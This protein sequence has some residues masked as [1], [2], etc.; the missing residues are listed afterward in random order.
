MGF[1]PFFFVLFL[2]FPLF[3]FSSFFFFFFFALVF[4][5]DARAFLV[6]LY[7]NLS[8]LRRCGL[9]IN[10]CDLNQWKW[11]ILEVEKIEKILE[12]TGLER[13]DIGQVEQYY[14]CLRE[15]LRSE[16]EKTDPVPVGKYYASL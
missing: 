12:K 9:R 6:F 3:F 4:V 13:M 7:S 11:K 14:Y 8:L 15:E 2:G 1:C 10:T 5:T 16:V